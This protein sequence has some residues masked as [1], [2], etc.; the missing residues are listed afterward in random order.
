MDVV[1]CGCMGFSFT[2]KYMNAIVGIHDIINEIVGTV[3]F[4]SYQDFQDIIAKKG[5]S[6]PSEIRMII[7]F[8]DK[9]KIVNHRN[10][11]R[12]TTRITSVLIDEFFFTSFGLE[13][14]NILKLRQKDDL[15]NKEVSNKIE[16]LFNKIGFLLFMNLCKTESEYIYKAIFGFLKKYNT[17]NHDEFYILTTAI[18]SNAKSTLEHNILKYRNGKIAEVNVKQ[19]VNDYQ[20]ITTMLV[21]IGI[22]E[23]VNNYYILTEKAEKL[24]IDYE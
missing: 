19:N 18:E 21:Q 9:A 4:V 12:S 16:N 10:L 8:L 24:E 17:I 6:K 2:E 23:K 13:F 3:D 11:I 22:L 1:G 15:S 14:I 20:Y 7:P 5:I